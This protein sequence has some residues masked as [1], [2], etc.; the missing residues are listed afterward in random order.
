M[1]SIS[2]ENRVQSV[3]S[4]LKLPNKGTPVLQRPEAKQLLDDVQRQDIAKVKDYSQKDFAQLSS[5]ITFDTNG[6]KFL[7]YDQ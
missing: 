4:A 5:R 7:F 1:R 3:S 2:I 6:C